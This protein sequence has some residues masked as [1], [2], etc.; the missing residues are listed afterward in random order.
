V[1]FTSNTGFKGVY[2][3]KYAPI[4]AYDSGSARFSDQVNWTENNFSVRSGSKPIEL[5]SATLGDKTVSIPFGTVV[6]DPDSWDEKTMEY[7]HM[8]VTC[9]R[10]QRSPQHQE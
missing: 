4:F 9:C 1:K 10:I 7:T 6:F 5:G 2:F 3:E 8:S